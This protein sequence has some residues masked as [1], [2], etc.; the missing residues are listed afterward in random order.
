MPQVTG[1]AQGLWSLKHWKYRAIAEIS[2]ITAMLQVF[3]FVGNGVLLDLVVQHQLLLMVQQ[4]ID[5]IG[6]GVGQLET[7]DLS[8]MAATL[9]RAATPKAE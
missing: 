9:A 4:L 2:S 3:I 5:G 1:L 6:V 8:S 7:L